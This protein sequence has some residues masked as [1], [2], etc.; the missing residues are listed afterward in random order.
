MIKH[1]QVER[2]IEPGSMDSP[3]ETLLQFDRATSGTHINLVTMPKDASRVYF[4]ISNAD[5]MV[6][7]VDKSTMY[8]QK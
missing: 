6:D 2:L 5:G 8:L 1:K 4:I 3:A 7:I